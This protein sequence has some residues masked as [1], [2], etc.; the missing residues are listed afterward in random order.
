MLSKNILRI[1]LGLIVILLVITLGFPGNSAAQGAFKVRVEDINNS[2]FPFVEA[3]VSVLDS[4]GLPLKDELADS[5]FSLTEDGVQV[6]PLGIE[7]FQNKEQALAVALLVDTSSSMGSIVKPEPLD[8]AVEAAKSFVEELANQDQVAVIKFSEK[9]EVVLGL[10]AANDKKV[11]LALDSLQPEK[12]KTALYDAIV[13]GV[14]ELKSF[15][16]RRIIVVV[17]DGKDTGTGL[18]DFDSAISGASAASIP[19]YPMGFG[20]V[21]NVQEMKR[22][23]ELTGGVAQIQPSIFDLQ[24]SFTTVL[25]ILRVQYR[26]R[27]ISKLPADNQSHNLTVFVDYQGGREQASFDFPAKSSAIPITMPGLKDDQV[28]GGLISFTPQLDWPA[29]LTSFEI[30]MDGSRLTEITSAPFSYE[31][32]STQKNV[33]SGPHDFLFKVTDI[34]GN[35]GQAKLRL[36]VQPPLTL[37]I[38]S[39][40]DGSTI[41]SATKI[42]ANVTTL[43]GITVARVDFL[44]DGKVIASDTTAP[45]EADWDVTKYPALTHP[46]SAIAY[47]GSGLFTSEAKTSVNV[48]VGSYSW[49]APLIVLAL[50]ALIIPIALRSRR[51]TGKSKTAVFVPTGSGSGQPV[52][53]EMEG[54]SPNQVWPLGTSEVRL[55]RKR[56]ENDIPLKG[57]NA[58]RRQASIRYEQGQYVIYT[59]SAN[60][61]VLVNNS[62]V[63][64]MQALKAGDIIRLGETVLHFEN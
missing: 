4:N 47:D 62:P 10:T 38:T 32:N 20:G 28:I 27:Y 61:P 9:P 21:I 1:L 56:D 49:M 55:G 43:P 19:I 45:F 7:K 13:T 53:R 15:S 3:Y 41:G 2:Q 42:T 23:A 63:T 6:N 64:N 44:V 37:E 18:F 24:A 25:D 8:K 26:I 34:A 30:S 22:M 35:V 58:S 12:S 16:G 29:P 51:R 5:A 59:L 39:P 36:N 14:N 11:V 52:L 50:A 54:M 46:V 60:N 57:L 31:W 33:P 17:T 40:T 48:E